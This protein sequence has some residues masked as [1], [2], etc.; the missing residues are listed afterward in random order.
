MARRDS[1]P[2]SERCALP[3]IHG[4]VAPHDKDIA[5]DCRLGVKRGGD[6]PERAVSRSLLPPA[7]STVPPAVLRSRASSSGGWSSSSSS[8]LM[9]VALLTADEALTTIADDFDDDDDAPTLPVPVPLLAAA[10]A[11]A[12]DQALNVDMAFSR[13][14]PSG[15]GSLRSDD[16]PGAAPT[17]TARSI[18]LRWRR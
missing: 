9:V 6:T 15:R 13:A 16:P 10:A 1:H 8:S 4:D 18:A 3:G 2:C 5:V 11:L 17:A 7:P 12:S 14:I